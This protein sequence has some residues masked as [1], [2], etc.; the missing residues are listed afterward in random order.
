LDYPEAQA[1]KQDLLGRRG[2]EVP[3][4]VFY[5]PVDLEVDGL[6][7]GLESGPFDSR[8][9]AFFTWLGVTVYLTRRAVESTLCYIGTLPSPSGIAFT[10]NLPRESLQGPDRD[11]HDFGRQVGAQRGEP[12]ITFYD[13]EPLSRW[14]EA[15]GFSE[16]YHLQ[17]EVADQRYCAGRTDGLRVPR[18]QQ[19]M[20]ATV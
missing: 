1:F 11:F 12:C 3:G 17:P 14:L 7:S 5:C 2:I 19:L 9:P 15:H 13:A 8:T 16:V 10:F 20:L 6:E 4:N 18:M